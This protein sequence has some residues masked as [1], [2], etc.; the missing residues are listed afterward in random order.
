M[1]SLLTTLGAVALTL[2]AVVAVPGAP[3]AGAATTTLTARR[4]VSVALGTTYPSLGTNEHYSSPVVA[5]LNGD[6]SPE[7]LVAAPNGTVT[8]TRLSNG[9]RLWQVK[10][11]NATIHATPVVEDMDGNGTVEVVAATMAGRVYILNG[12]T[13][14]TVKTFSQGPPLHCPPGRDC[15]PDGFFAT[16]AV[17]DVNGDGIK[18]IVAPSFDHT[19]YAWSRGGTLLWRTYLEDTLWSSPVIV[20]ID[21]NGRN[22]VVLGGDIW[23][24]NPFGAP[25]GGLL[26]ALNGANGSR[27]NGYPISI[28]G[29]TVWSSP[30]VT[31]LDGDG[32]LEAVFGTG[33]NFPASATTRRVYAYTLTT[34]RPLPGWPISVS[35]QVLQQPAIA[36]IDNDGA[37]EVVVATE[38]G[39]VRAFEADGS[40]RWAVCNST[41]RNCPISGTHN[42]VA[43][44]DV[45]D[46]GVQEV[47]ATN[48]RRIRVFAAGNGTLEAEYPLAG[49][50]AIAA[51]VPAISELNGEAVIVHTGIYRS[52]TTPVEVRSEVLGTG[53]QLCAEDWPQFRRG[54]R[55]GSVLPDR[56]PWHP[57]PC[58]RPFVT[59]QYRDLLGRNLDASGLA[60]WTARLRTTWTGPRVVHGFMNSPEFGGVAAPVVRLHIGLKGGTPGPASDIRAGMAVLQRD[61]S[62]TAAVAEEILAD[63]PPAADDALVSAVFP[64]LTGRT[65]TTTERSTALQR[66]AAVGQAQWAAELSATTSAV[67]NLRSEVQVAMAYVG[68]LARAPDASGYAYWVGLVDRGTSPQRLIEQFLNTPEYRNR[69]A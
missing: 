26:W 60:Y 32:R 19:V 36:D 61:P 15:R 41:S 44:A 24:G 48:E 10:L 9:Q 35:G 50:Y 13:G 31:D 38:G 34:R 14:A 68:L 22:E 58:A 6:D 65:P 7:L 39:Y 54:P 64:R 23:A 11:G 17:G 52:G 43:I 28:P 18:D 57:F 69:V 66:I 67:T 59:Q 63:L 5:D 51:N 29:Q 20:D 21:R 53:E 45:D 47:V 1:R 33:S 12:Q 30:A 55:R 37:R 2:A 56:A 3:P 46:D 42:G 25:A 62:A 27:L 49:N 16:P 8:A 40:Q 4:T